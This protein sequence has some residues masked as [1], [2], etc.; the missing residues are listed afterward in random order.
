VGLAPTGKRRLF[1]APP[2]QPQANGLSL[3]RKLVS[4]IAFS[5]IQHRLITRMTRR[6]NERCP[7]CKKVVRNLLAA[8]F[9]VVEV[10]WDLGLPCAM[11]DYKSTSQ[12]AVLC[13][14]Y[15]AL[16]KHR[17]FDYFVRSKKLPR[18]DFFIPDRSLIFEFDESQHFTKPRDIALSNYSNYKEFWFSLNR[19]RTL[20]QQLDRRDN[21]PP[22]R[23]EQRAWY[24]TLRDFAPMLLGVGRTVRLYSRDAVWCSLNPNKESDLHTFEG[25]V[26]S[27]LKDKKP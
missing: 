4:V 27:T 12:G 21:D 8:R 2:L 3:L 19:W 5:E 20:C 24:D 16:I 25:L 18:V 11:A 23:D 22:F 17:G 13:R 9:G 1:T 15:E 14:I 26:S 7:D 10:N 6:H